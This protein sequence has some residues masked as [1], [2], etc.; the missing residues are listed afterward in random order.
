MLNARCRGAIAAALAVAALGSVTT[1]AHAATGLPPIRHVFVI[2]LENKE[3]L[4]WYAP[5]PVA[6]PYL[7]QTLAPEGA[8]VPNYFGTGHSSADNYIAMISGQPPTSDSKND[9]SFPL[10]SV[11]TAQDANG[12]AQGNG[13]RY[14]P[15]YKTIGDQMTAAGLTWHA[16]AE[17]MPS[18]C[19]PVHDAPGNYA[20]KHNAFPYFESGVEDGD[21]AQNDVPLIANGTDQLQSDLQSVATTA[22]VNYIF[23]DQCN[24]GHSDCTGTNPIP[25]IGSEADEMAQ[26]D[27]FLKH[28]VPLITGSPAFKQDGL[29]VITVDEGD[30]PFGCCGEPMR[31][32]DGSYP[33]GEAGS[34]GNGGGQVGA[35]LLSRFITPGTTSTNMYNH[36]SLLASIEDL[37]G[38]PRLG[39][40]NLLGTTTFGSDIYTNPAG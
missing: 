15:Q 13:C 24:D 6:D 35:V 23:P 25:E 37:F 28:Y 31:D 21:C 1:T 27:G 3:F 34:P 2:V 33:G 22:N 29:L 11:G 40:T 12:V 16:Y 5:G 7:S 9:C 36:Y 17:N 4:E 38:L 10:R 32:P 18:D 30:D 8:L 19:S 26:Y 39:E 20:L 14:P